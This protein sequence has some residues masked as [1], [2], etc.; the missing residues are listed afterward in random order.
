MS[1]SIE[2][3]FN[4]STIAITRA[5]TSYWDSGNKAYNSSDL[6]ASGFTGSMTFQATA[7]SNCSFKQWVYHVGKISNPTQY[8]TS[9][10]FVYTG[11]ENIYIRA[12]GQTN[13]TTTPTDP[14][15]W[16]V[17]AQSVGLVSSSYQKS[18]SV[19]EYQIYR[20]SVSFANSGTATFYSSGSLDTRGFL[21]TSTAWSS[22]T[23][24]PTNILTEDDDSGG[25][26]NFSFT[27]SVTA[28]TTYYLYLR[29]Y[30]DQYSGTTTVN[31]TPPAGSSRPQ[32]GQI[33]NVSVTSDSI[34]VRGTDIAGATSY[35]FAIR[36]SSDPSSATLYYTSSE[37]SY[38][39]S[40]LS[41]ST[42]YVVNYRGMND[43][44]EGVYGTSQNVTTSSQASASGYVYIYTSSGWKPA[45]PYIYDSGSGEWKVATPYIY[46]NGW[47]IAS[48]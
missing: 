34:T 37:S 9:N 48:S 29:A 7:A 31:I 45:V 23:G 5:Y 12:E 39:F 27:Y 14:T 21:S 32:A 26:A 2:C 20:L 40:G 22:S 44:Y 47:K 30:S 28:N 15:S 25:S 6:V 8:S 33:T 41:P 19:G 4:D 24:V 46:N 36:K 10:P 43:S 18:F 13:G 1:Y 38:T 3:Y 17:T 35:Q 16:Y 11:E 42:T